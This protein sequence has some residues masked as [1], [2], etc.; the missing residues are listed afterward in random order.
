MCFRMRRDFLQAPLLGATRHAIIFAGKQKINNNDTY[1]PAVRF[2]VRGPEQGETARLSVVTYCV[3]A[4]L[5]C[6][7]DWLIVACV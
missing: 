3:R 1:T 5:M 4:C 2:D 6:Y 7:D